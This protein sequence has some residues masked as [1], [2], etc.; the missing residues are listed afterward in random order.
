MWSLIADG[1]SNARI[2]G[3]L[4]V[5]ENTVKFHVQ[6]LFAK[7]GVR[8]RTEAAVRHAAALRRGET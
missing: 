6:H 3:R 8:N 4:R 5:S 2:A 1:L 7:L